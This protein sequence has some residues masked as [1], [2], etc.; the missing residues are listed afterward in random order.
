MNYGAAISY[1]A[2]DDPD[3]VMWKSKPG[4]R[5]AHL[6]AP[7]DEGQFGV[8]QPWIP[9][10]E[11]TDQAEEMMARIAGMTGHRPKELT[12]F[13]LFKNNKNAWQMSVQRKD[14]RGWDV[15]T[16]TD[17]EAQAVF[18]T[19]ETADY[20]DGPVTVKPLASWSAAKVQQTQQT[21]DR[22]QRLLE[23]LRENEAARREATEALAARLAT[24]GAK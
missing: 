23:L 18:D 11:L 17:D 21:I 2:P 20:P 8:T 9:D 3:I 7:R 13:T 16:I 4:W 14:D 15:K 24:R 19:L 6:D 22:N 5:I 12:G 1:F 10:I